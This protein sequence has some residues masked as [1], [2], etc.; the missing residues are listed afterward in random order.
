[1]SK[2]T[3]GRRNILKA[4]A[5]SLFLAGMPVTGF[6]KA[7]PPGSISVIILEGGMD[8]LA[9]MPPIGDPDLMRMRQS[10]TPDNYLALNDFFGLHPSLKFYAQLMAS[11]HASAVHATAFPYTKRSHFEGQNLIEGGGLSPFSE[12]TGWLGRALDL[13]GVAGRSLSLDMPLI[14]RGYHENDNFY[15]ASIRGSKKPNANLLNMIAMGHHMDAAQ[16]FT[17]VARK[18]EDNVQVPRDPASLAKYAGRAMAQVDGPVA[19]V[20][21]VSEFDSH[22]NQTEDGNTNEGRLARQLSVVDD[23]IAGYRRGLGEAWDDAII[24]TLTEFGRTV[25]VNGT[26]GTDHGYASVG[27]LAGGSL[28][29]SGVITDWPGLS[30]K[31]QFEK[32]DLMATIDYRSVCAAC[33]EK[34]LGLD[35]DL[36]AQQVFQ[37][38]D[39]PRMFDHLFT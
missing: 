31:D 29:N 2:L 13:S 6:A 36:I 35:H 22:S 39:L 32:R 33:I 27:L 28:S 37:Q 14:L 1:M 3:V 25:A 7:K 17:K 5:A 16:L 11:G 18:S 8:G 26:K 24:L 21:R 20:I 34:S 4:G 38:P 9:A 23:V 30:K 19:S 15:P 10:V 12:K